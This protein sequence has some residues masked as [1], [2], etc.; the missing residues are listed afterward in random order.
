MPDDTRKFRLLASRVE[1]ATLVNE[2][3]HTLMHVGGDNP[4]LTTHETA[5][6]TYLRSEQMVPAGTQLSIDYIRA[7][8]LRLTTAIIPGLESA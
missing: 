4:D 8:A 7:I 2:I 6:V 5:A 1:F 3:T